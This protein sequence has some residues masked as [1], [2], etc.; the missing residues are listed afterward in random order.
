MPDPSP[1]SALRME[2]HVFD[3][4][5]TPPLECDIYG[6]ANYPN[7]T[8]LVQT[9]YFRKW[10][11]ISA[12]YRLLPAVNGRDLLNDATAAY[13]F[14]RT[15]VGGSHIPRRVI[16]GG[17]SAGPSFVFCL[18]S[19]PFPY[20]NPSANLPS[21]SSGFFLA[22]LIAYH[23]E[24]KPLALLS[25]TGIPTFHHP[26]FNSYKL[27]YHSSLDPPELVAPNPGPIPEDD[28]QTL[29]SPY[30]VGKSVVEPLD[31]FALAKLDS[32]GKRKHGNAWLWRRLHHVS[33]SSQPPGVLYNYY[34]N[35]IVYLDLVSAVDPG[36]DWAASEDD[37]NLAR[38][39]QW[40]MTIFI[41][42]EQDKDISP[43]VCRDVAVRLGSRAVYCEARDQG[44]LF[45]KQLFL[46][47][48]QLN[49]GK[50]KGMSALFKAIKALDEAVGT[51]KENRIFIK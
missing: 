13:E 47:N 22:T 17:A 34:L 50:T 39:S 29:I 2:T 44:H 9:C 48:P 37:A 21:I 45:E 6:A 15:R 36:F 30:F 14:A 23:L 10:F 18:A 42:G 38:T 27:I 20:R 49:R 5:R 3:P 43:S 31:A 35:K 33:S 32:R 46:D 41:Q 19:S 12:S 1:G 26:F 24:P 16:V 8:P 4:R 25:I 7:D 40:P 28:M 11:L 51:P